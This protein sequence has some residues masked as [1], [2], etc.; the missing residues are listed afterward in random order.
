[1]GLERPFLVGSS[2]WRRGFE[3][4]ELKLKGRNILS[5]GV[6]FAWTS[7]TSYRLVDMVV[8]CHVTVVG[9]ARPPSSRSPGQ[10]PM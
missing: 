2:D 6:A 10:R 3:K 8:Q 1:M 5:S 4:K 9:P 7:K